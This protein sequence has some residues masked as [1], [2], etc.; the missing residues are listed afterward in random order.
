MYANCYITDEQEAHDSK[1]IVYYST[2]LL[3]RHIV[4]MKACI[5]IFSPTDTPMVIMWGYLGWD[6]T[7]NGRNNKSFVD[8]RAKQ[9]EAFI[10][11]ISLSS[12]QFNKFTNLTHFN[13]LLLW[14]RE[15][16]PF[17]VLY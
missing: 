14:K 9:L 4:I 1:H 12:K 11:F 7:E 13:M 15:D 10:T 3:K 5:V 2:A 17:V 16:N 6:D 8:N